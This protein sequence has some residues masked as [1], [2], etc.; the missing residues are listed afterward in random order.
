M[1]TGEKLKLK[2]I[3]ETNQFITSLVQV[4]LHKMIGEKAS[5]ENKPD[6][7][8]KRPEFLELSLQTILPVVKP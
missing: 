1:K 2:M 5:V 7:T 8:Q 3:V 6:K 4:T